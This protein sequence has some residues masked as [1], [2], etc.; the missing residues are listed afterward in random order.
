MQDGDYD[1]HAS[2]IPRLTEKFRG[3]NS[4]VSDFYNELKLIGMLENVTVVIASEF[5]R[6]R[7]KMPF[8][9][10]SFIASVYLIMFHLLSSVAHS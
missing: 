6:V 10:F 1:H 9:N 5:G 2:M 7:L 4:G 3:L 8:L